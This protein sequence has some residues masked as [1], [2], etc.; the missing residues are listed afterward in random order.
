M[1]TTKSGIETPT[2]YKI[3]PTPIRTTNFPGSSKIGKGGNSGTDQ[4]PL[5]KK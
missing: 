5:S 3:K 2:D 1:A 4:G